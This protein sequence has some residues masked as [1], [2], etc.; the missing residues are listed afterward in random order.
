MFPSA[1][2]NAKRGHREPQKETELAPQ[3][4]AQTDNA[5]A[6]ISSSGIAESSA[7][8]VPLMPLAYDKDVRRINQELEEEENG[9]K[10]RK[11]TSI[12][13]LQARRVM[14]HDKGDWEDE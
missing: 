12:E 5:I 10:P 1:A 14:A 4:R 6:T 7:K 8:A 3:K 2:P 9:P 13:R 11:P